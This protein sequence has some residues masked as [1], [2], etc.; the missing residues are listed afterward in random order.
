[1][2][3]VCFSGVTGWAAAPI[4][5]GIA[6]SD[7]L[8]LVAGVSRSA[9]GRTVAEVTG[10]GEGVVYASVEDALAGA[11]FD[12]LVDY[13]S[14]EVVRDHV[15]AGVRAGV[16]VVVGS[17]GLS[18]ED[19]AELDV[20]AREKGVGVFAAGNFS[21]LA[22]VL[23]KAA[24]L[25]AEQVPSWEIV[26]YASAEKPD[27]PSGTARE[28]AEA[29]ARVRRP[30]L[31]VPIE[32]LHGPTEARGADI[33]GTRVHSLR[34]P[35]YVIATEVVFGSGGEKLVMNHDPGPGPQP[36]AAGTL[37]AIRRVG[38]QAGVRR[39]LD[40]LLFS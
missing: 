18:G 32:N 4:I 23:L 21:L 12:V 14:A 19:Y 11:E 34:L 10:T 35:G 3:R 13:T 31:A 16:H 9:A 29:L 33:A 15:F 27:V 39:G 20:V 22:A 17:S 28:L 38:D 2:L 40:T 30:E 36:Y 8:L 25:A 5:A 37:L 6:S 7:D 24:S 26:D 1:M